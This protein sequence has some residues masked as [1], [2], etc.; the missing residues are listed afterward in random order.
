MGQIVFLG[1]VVVFI[2]AVI[3]SVGKKKNGFVRHSSRGAFM[4]D[5][6]KKMEEDK[7]K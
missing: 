3:Y 7:P 2:L 5:L 4:N 1:V 6:N